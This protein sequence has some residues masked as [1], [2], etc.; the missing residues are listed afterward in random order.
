MFAMFVILSE[1]P[2]VEFSPL[3]EVS[4][5]TLGGAFLNDL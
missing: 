4:L 2:F 5:V 3:F 1:Q